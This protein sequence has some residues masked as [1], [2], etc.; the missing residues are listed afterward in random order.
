[1]RLVVDASVAIKWF[2][3][4]KGQ[5]K[6]QKILNQITLGQI[7][8]V[9]PELFFYEIGNI[10]LTK[11]TG[12]SP[13]KDAVAIFQDLQ[14]ETKGDTLTHLGNIFDLAAEYSLSFYDAAYLILAIQ[15]NCQ[16][17]TADKKLY[18]KVSKSFPLMKLL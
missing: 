2:F 12:S 7:D 10:F 16:F 1:M 3:K 5:Q 6:A 11:R 17:I 18:Q 9:V 15:E 14:F 4:E 8:A 13:V